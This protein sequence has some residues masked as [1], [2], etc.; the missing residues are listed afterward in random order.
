VKNI[1]FLQNSP[2]HMNG[3]CIVALVRESLMFQARGLATCLALRIELALSV[4]MGE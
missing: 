2:F 1:I 3:N 4:F